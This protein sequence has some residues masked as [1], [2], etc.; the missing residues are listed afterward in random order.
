MCHV[1]I[2]DRRNRVEGVRDD[3]GCEGS[4]NQQW[5]QEILLRDDMEVSA[6]SSRR[7]SIDKHM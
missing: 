4:A 6:S 1:G 2:Q 5:Q 7:H 3:A